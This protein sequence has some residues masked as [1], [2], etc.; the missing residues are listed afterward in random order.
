MMIDFNTLA[1]VTVPGMNGGQGEMTAKMSV[2]EQ[3]KIIVSQ[4]HPGSSIGVHQH[5]TSDDINYVL[6]GQGIAI[7]D[8]REESLSPG[9]CH[10]CPQGS[11]HSIANTGEDA[12]C[13]LTVVVE[14]A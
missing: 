6:S 12:L 11:T 2:S 10:I 8:G 7:C 14:R 13:L 9:C 4:I 1:A 5:D 3:G